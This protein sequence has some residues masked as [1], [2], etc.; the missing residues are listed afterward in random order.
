MPS[1]ELLVLEGGDH[2]FSGYA[3]Q[4]ALLPKLTDFILEA[5]VR[6]VE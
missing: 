6:G 1:H 4:M 3:E 2:C 5:C